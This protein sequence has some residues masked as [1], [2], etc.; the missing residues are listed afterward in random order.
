[1]PALS[2][3]PAPTRTVGAELER[4]RLERRAVRL[5]QVLA[6]LASDARGRVDE[7]GAVPVPLARSIADF[8]GE[9]ATV[10]A[11]LR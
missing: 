6:I 10:R 8:R 9:L 1:M 4:V 5:Q 11:Q 2:L 7:S 3:A